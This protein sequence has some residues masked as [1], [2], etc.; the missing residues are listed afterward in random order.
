MLWAFALNRNGTSAI[1]EPTGP[2]GMTQRTWAASAFSVDHGLA[3]YEEIRHPATATGTRTVTT[4][5]ACGSAV[6]KAFMAK[7]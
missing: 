3:V 7:A 1:V 5:N 2:T 4:T 6:M